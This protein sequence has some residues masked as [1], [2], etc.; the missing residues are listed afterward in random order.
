MSIFF[1]YYNLSNKMFLYFTLNLFFS[2]NIIYL[3]YGKN[4]QGSP[5]NKGL[6]FRID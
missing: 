5:N 1:Y 6:N 3:I 4:I 2:K